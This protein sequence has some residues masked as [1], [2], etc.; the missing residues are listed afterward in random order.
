MGQR[1]ENAKA[2]YLGAI[3]DGNVAEAMARYAGGRYTQHS[4]P[5]KDGSAGSSI[6]EMVD[7][8]ASGHSQVD[9]PTELTDLEETEQNKAL[10]ADFLTRE[11]RR[12]RRAG[13]LH[14]DRDLRSAQPPHR[15]WDRCPDR[16]P[17]Q[18]CRAR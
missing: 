9:G 13:P 2:L 12:D 8:A 18:P 10:V 1:L 14:L 6:A 5:V 11:E 7:D 16:V 17:R 4:T 3:R 15:R